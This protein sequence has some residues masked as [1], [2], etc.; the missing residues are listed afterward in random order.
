MPPKT[1]QPRLSRVLQ[2]IWAS[3]LWGGLAHPLWADEF[4]SPDILILGD[5]Q[6][7]FG[8]GPAFLEFFSNIV[9]SCT[10]A[11][12]SDPRLPAVSDQ[13][14]AGRV[15]VI[16]VRSTSI[17]HWT[18]RGG[19]AKDTIC[20]VDPRWRVNAGTFGYINTTGN[21]YVQIGQGA[22]YQ[23]CR[24]GRSAF[25]AMFQDDYYDPKLLLM[26]FM[27]NS[28][29]TWADNPDAAR[30]DVEA[31]MAQLPPDLPCIFMTTAPAYRADIVEMRL[32]AQ[33]NVMAAFE[34]TGS[35]CSVVPGATPETIAA[36]QGNAAHFRRDSSGHVR[37]PF[38][39]N[40]AAAEQFFSLQM[41]LICEAVFE[42][43]GGR[44]RLAS[45]FRLRDQTV[46]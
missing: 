23:F 3:I 13:L 5:S 15:A 11:E 29:R 39:P 32:R 1:K 6:I 28:A 8:A 37:D 7:S 14:G 18:A 45:V 17:R 42:Q 46:E 33:E 24:P 22:P 31:L 10:A 2:C 41:G 25:E 44:G 19:S 12:A 16:G 27:G 20:E 40:T 9:G 34:E 35:H 38:H 21:K 36:N 43:L 30:R 4:V 26:S